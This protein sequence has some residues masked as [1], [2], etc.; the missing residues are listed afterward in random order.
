M[1]SPKWKVLLILVLLM[2][3]ACTAPMREGVP[4]Q[5]RIANAG[6]ENIKNLVVLFPGE[7]STS[8]AVRVEFGDVP[9]GSISN[10]VIASRGVYR[11]AAYEYESG[12]QRILQPVM[13]WVGEKPLEGSKFT[14]RLKLDLSKTVGEQIELVDVLTD[15]K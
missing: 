8:L 1:E 9:A 4:T 15:N 2:A 13:D 6:A 5:L 12:G 11:Y 14:Y 3:S 10:Y 7:F